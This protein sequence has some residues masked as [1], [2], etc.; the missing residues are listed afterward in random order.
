MLEYILLIS[1]SLFGPS[2]VAITTFESKQVFLVDNGFQQR[3]FSPG[4]LTKIYNIVMLWSWAITRTKIYFPRFEN[5]THLQA[6]LKYLFNIK[7]K[8]RRNILACQILSGAKYKEIVW[9]RNLWN[10]GDGNLTTISIYTICSPTNNNSQSSGPTWTFGQY[11]TSLQNARFAA[12][13][14]DNLNV[15]LPELWE[16]WNERQLSHV[17]TINLEL[18]RETHGRILQNLSEQSKII[19]KWF[20]RLRKFQLNRPLSRACLET[21]C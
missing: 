5:K 3:S 4:H 10:T 7:R 18:L 20:I 14:C 9:Y 16:H 6:I 1:K 8:M 2:P 12:L 21:F 13:F 19:I 11:A 17:S 15:I